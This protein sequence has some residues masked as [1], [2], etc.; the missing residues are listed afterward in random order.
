MR[1]SPKVAADAVQAKPK[2]KTQHFP[3]AVK[4]VSFQRGTGIWN[5][6]GTHLGPA[7]NITAQTSFADVKPTFKV[8]VDEKTRTITVTVDATSTSKAHLGK[9][10]QPE[11]Y[12]IPTDRPQALNEKY[13]LVVKDI[14]GKT[15]KKTSFVNILPC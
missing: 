1:I 5:P 12:S 6:N 10:T 7:V 13:T 4:D 3:V 14:A 9:K 2:S 15:L 8:K 11:D